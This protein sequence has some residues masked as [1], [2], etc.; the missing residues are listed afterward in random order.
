MKMSKLPAVALAMALIATAG[1]GACGRNGVPQLPK[2][3]H[4]DKYPTQYPQT[5]RPQTGIF[6][7]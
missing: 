1:L 5:P 6:S 2:E 7:G 3:V 4:K